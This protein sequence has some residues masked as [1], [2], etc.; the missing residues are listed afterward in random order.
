M[1]FSK[2]TTE[3]KRVIN[4]VASILFEKKINLE[5]LQKLQ[6]AISIDLGGGNVSVAGTSLTE[7]DA[8]IQTLKMFIRNEESIW[9]MVGFDELP[10]SGRGGMVSIGKSVKNRAYRYS[11]YKR[12]PTNDNL[13]IGFPA[14]NDPDNE[15][16]ER[17]LEE[18]TKT[19]LSCLM[20]GILGNKNNR[21]LKE[22]PRDKILVIVGHPTSERWKDKE[23]RQNLETMIR[24]A[25]GVSQVLTMAESNSAILYAMKNRTNLGAAARVLIIDLGATTA[26]ITYIDKVTR[27]HVEASIDLGGKEIDANVETIGIDKSGIKPENVAENLCMETR[28]IKEGHWPKGE[29]EEDLTIKQKNGVSVTVTLT[30]GDFYDAVTDEKYAFSVYHELSGE[31]VTDSYTGHLK[32]FLRDAKRGRRNLDGSHVGGIES[33]DYVLITGGAARM[34]PAKETIIQSVNELWDVSEDHIW[35]DKI[36]DSLINDA[37][38]HGSLYYYQKAQNTLSGLPVLYKNL[39]TA[40]KSMVEPMAEKIA[41]ELTPYLMEDVIKVQAK[42]WRDHG[43]G[44][45]QEDLEDMIRNACKQE[46]V[47]ER[48]QRICA[49]AMNKEA[50]MHFVT[51]QTII[52]DFMNELYGAKA[53]NAKWKMPKVNMQGLNVADTVAA[54]ISA[55]L[56]DR[57]TSLLE[58]ILIIAIGILVIPI[59]VVVGIVVGVAENVTDWLYDTFADAK[60]NMERQ[61]KKEEKQKQED[62]EQRSK[63]YDKI[64]ANSNYEKLQAEM[65]PQ[66]SKLLLAEYEKNAFGIPE[67]YMTQLVDDI[68]KFVYTG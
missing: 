42:E 20:D 47:Q 50:G 65:V 23:A 8:R 25:T 28:A 19:F 12:V 35:P 11:N 38:S 62:L 49:A 9:S 3:E 4:K 22:C 10:Q 57:V 63:A 31:T 58:D 24:E 45:K 66:I 27:R 13:L 51:F 43:T 41:G 54:Q 40:G 46:S 56:A 6:Q 14:D 36:N 5:E 37:V 17:T 7:S 67:A 48:C 33:V 53:G 1:D 2:L 59:A 32:R 16:T 64:V 18:L 21:Q 55:A 61:K 68:R 39:K 15:A 30:P 29:S 60:T 34:K 44:C 52:T 26:D